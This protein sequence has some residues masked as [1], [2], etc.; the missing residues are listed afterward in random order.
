MRD[1]EL[2]K[3][4]LEKWVKLSMKI[5]EDNLPMLIEELTYATQAVE[6]VGKKTMRLS[7]NKKYD[8]S[9]VITQ[10]FLE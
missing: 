6:T 1:V 9:L 8:C 10:R 2:E 4:E 3:L 7:G 5:F